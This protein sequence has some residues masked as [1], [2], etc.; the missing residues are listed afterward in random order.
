[1]SIETMLAEHPHVAPGTNN[2]S[3]GLAV[4]QAME[5]AAICNSCAD[6]C[7][8][9][10]MDM[11]QCIR[12]C[13]DCADVCTTTYRVGSRRTGGDRQL[14]RT[15]LATCIE[16]CE[17]CAEECEFHAGGHAHCRTCAQMCHDCAAACRAALVVLNDEAHR[18]SHHI[19][20]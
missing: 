19:A 14:I 18:D 8:A 13:S 6:A 2:A 15:L 17:R 5:C 20:H 12:L 10:P 11:R 9:E 16:V 1:M 7:I 3:L 4:R